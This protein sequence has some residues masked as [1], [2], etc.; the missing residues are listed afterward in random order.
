[1]NC[2]IRMMNKRRSIIRKSP[3]V[4]S[5]DFHKQTGIVCGWHYIDETY[6]NAQIFNDSCN[7]KQSTSWRIY[8]LL[9]KHLDQDAKIPAYDI[10]MSVNIL[11]FVSFA[12]QNHTVLQRYEQKCYEI[13]TA[14]TH[15]DERTLIVDLM[16]NTMVFDIW[17]NGNESPAMT[18][19]ICDMNVVSFKYHDKYDAKI[20]TV[21]KKISHGVGHDIERL[22]FTYLCGNDHIA[23][24]LYKEFITQFNQKK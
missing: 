23:R 6:I 9:H 20:H 3:S 18:V 22:I 8:E 12:R 1:M 2:S 11:D 21:I 19:V 17:N 16:K 24:G 5:Y 7:F 10:I 4:C 13:A 14:I 15:L